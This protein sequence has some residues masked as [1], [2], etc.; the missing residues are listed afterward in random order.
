VAQVEVVDDEYHRL[1][2]QRQLVHV[3][4]AGVGQQAIPLEMRMVARRELRQGRLCRIAV[5]AHGARDAREE[6]AAKHGIGGCGSSPAATAQHKMP[7]NAAAPRMRERDVILMSL[8]CSHLCLP[9]FL[10]A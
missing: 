3:D 1:E 9:L 10:I 4:R 8:F 6:A 7:A 5:D 2:L